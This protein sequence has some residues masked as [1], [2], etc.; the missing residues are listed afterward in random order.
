M[1]RRILG[2][3]AFALIVLI[4]AAASVFL[5]HSVGKVRESY[6]AA[7]LLVL[8]AALIYIG[9]RRAGKSNGADGENR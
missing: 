6:V 8:S 4:A 5:L 1:L 9:G 3:N 7:G 2:S